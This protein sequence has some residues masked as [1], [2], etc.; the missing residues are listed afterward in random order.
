M[1]RHSSA[2]T[3]A[4]L[5]TIATP[6]LA[7]EW[8]KMSEGIQGSSYIDVATIRRDGDLAQVWQL[9]NLNQAGRA[10][11]MSRQLL[12]EYDCTDQL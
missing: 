2:F 7:A 5:A 1:T 9:Q 11:E 8:L 4:L 10:G 3:F 6:T 12:V